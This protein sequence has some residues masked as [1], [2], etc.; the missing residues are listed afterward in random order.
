MPPNPST[1]PCSPVSSDSCSGLRLRRACYRRGAPRAYHQRRSCAANDVA[2]RRQHAHS[3]RRGLWFFPLTEK[4]H[5]QYCGGPYEVTDGGAILGGV[6]L[7]DN[8]RS[9]KHKEQRNSE[10]PSHITAR[11]FELDDHTDP[12]D[13]IDEAADEACDKCG[14]VAVKFL[15]VAI[16]Q[17]CQ[18]QERIYGAK[19]TRSRVRAFDE[20]SMAIWFVENYG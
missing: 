2:G 12:E 5:N 13:W 1:L 7:E 17:L 10:K 18:R 20:A 9:N 6:L 4:E 14:W 15:S 19:V 11:T 16:E 8:H 3:L